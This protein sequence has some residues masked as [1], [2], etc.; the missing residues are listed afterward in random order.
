MNSL[1][2]PALIEAKAQEYW[3]S[4]QI[5]E[6]R[7]HL[8]QEKFYCL[9]MLPYPSGELHVGH[10]RNY[11][12][13]DVISRY[14]R[15]QGKNV[16]QPM[17]WDAFGL[18][19][20]NAAIKHGLSPAVWTE[21]NIDA[22]RQ[23]IKD[24]GC[25]IAWHREIKTC[26]PEYYRWEQWLF[27]K[28]F[29]KQL[30]YKKNSVV[31]WDPIDQTVLANEQV[32]NGCGWRSG[33]PIERREISQ[34]FLKITQYADELVDE[35]DHLTGWPEQVIS[36]Q[37]HWIGRSRGLQI[38]FTVENSR[39]PLVIFTTRP[40]TLYG[41]TYLAIAF[42]HPLAKEA[43]IANPAL[44]EFLEACSHTKVAEADVAKQDKLGI[45]SGR[46]AI[47]PE[48][49]EKLPIWITNFVLMEYGTG[50]V[51]SVPAHDQRDFEFA[52]KYQLP[53]KPV[54]VSTK[55]PEW[56]YEKSAMTE[57]GQ[58]I[59]SGPYT[60]LM[61]NAAFEAMTEHGLGSL[62]TN[63][64]LRD[65]GI[66]RQRYWGTP[67]PIIY[68]EQCGTVPVPEK[69]LPVVLPLNI[70]PNGQGSP[71]ADCEEF[72]NT[73][74]PVCQGEAK[75]ETDTMDTFVE[76]SWYYA[77]YCCFDQEQAMLD[78]RAKYWTPVDQYIGGIEHACMHL[79]YARFF[80]K[81]MRDEGLLNSDEPFTRL[82]TQGMV[83]KDGAKMSKSKGNVVNPN[84][85]IQR[86]GAD[87]LRL[88]IMFAAP[89][90]QSLEWSDS[91]VE[92]C[93]RFLR[94]LW[95]YSMDAKEQISHLN[96][97]LR[98]DG[99]IAISHP[100]LLK[101]RKQLH[102]TLQQ[103]TQD[104]ERYQYNTVVS[105]AMI[106]MN[107][108]SK[109]DLNQHQEDTQT[110]EA[111]HLV[112][113]GLDLL[114]RLLAPITPHICHELWRELNFGDDILEADWPKANPKALRSSELE[115]IVQVNGK[116]RGRLNVPADADAKRIE[117]TVL[118]DPSIQRYLDNKPVRKCIIVPGRLVNIV[119]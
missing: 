6:V 109:L 77:R 39:K 115:L 79:L 48:T 14:Q 92:G 87:T 37:R 69:D 100:E 49:R 7:E 19:A 84:D 113:E 16:L 98:H 85:L 97:K 108:L 118:A 10:V 22:M 106:M 114:L 64:R 112:R 29:K 13:G 44:A 61:S 47:H 17:G 40:D 53:I 24:L 27:L 45:F 20:E 89:P 94:K 103:A 68:C 31:N 12:I 56:D 119:V 105:A 50:A 5:F 55:N 96:Q 110:A 51:M 104:F 78:D 117:A 36:M 3:S 54:I 18:P 33:A 73:R 74:C 88:F 95:M 72:I 63:Y 101:T 4:S 80:H 90:E 2:Q 32:V 30:A 46:Y 116:L 11:T 1:Y 111:A 58:L 91:G 34:W 23:Q 67:I 66:S 70:I 59:N 42:D 76:S 93:Y 81:V 65:W 62:Q 107:L 25:A 35:L 82:L 71:L 41:V 83:L 99:C 21:K 57:P 15:M 38:Q 75:R 102:Q 60:G 86:F 52:Q 9:S 43:A 28:L 8:G 26:D